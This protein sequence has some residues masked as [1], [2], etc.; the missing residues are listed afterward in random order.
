M[1]AMKWKGI[2]YIR[3]DA[4]GGFGVNMEMNVGSSMRTE[5]TWIK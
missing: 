3:I 2:A 5:D 1:N 4:L